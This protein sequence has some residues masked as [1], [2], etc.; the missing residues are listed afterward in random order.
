M[1]MS[2]HAYT[3]HPKDTPESR[4]DHSYTPPGLGDVEGDLPSKWFSGGSKEDLHA[5][6]GS[7]LDLLV[8]ALPL[9]PKTEK[10]ISTA[11]FEV[12]KKKRTFLSNI[13]R[14]PIVD[15]EALY[16]ALENEDIRGAAL[17]VTDPEPLPDG[18]KLWGAKNIIITPHVSGRSVS[19]KDRS[20]AI[21]KE[22]LKSLAEGEEFMNRVNRKDGY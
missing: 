17:D 11:E 8:I 15:S 3:L 2:V 5:F 20:F 22:N 1:G 12:L 10:L 6:L 14:G 9:T 13:G 18:D 4:R 7:D 16:Q 19:Y 21:L